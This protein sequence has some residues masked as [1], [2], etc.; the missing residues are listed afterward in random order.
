MKTLHCDICRNELVEPIS[1]RNYWHIREYDLCED[2]KDGIELKLRPII[3]KHFPFSQ[4]WY[5]HEF[6]SVI[7]KGVAAKRP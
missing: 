6:I 7:E 4:D 1:G 5:E 3:R 2:C